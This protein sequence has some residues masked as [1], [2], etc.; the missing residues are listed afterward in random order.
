MSAAAPIMVE[1]KDGR[2]LAGTP[3]S[4]PEYKDDGINELYLTHPEARGED[5]EWSHVGAAI[6]VPLSEI[7]SIVLSEDPTNAPVSLPGNAAQG[8]QPA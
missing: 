4:G 8:G 3:R 2:R 5:G 1:F 6:I 7:S